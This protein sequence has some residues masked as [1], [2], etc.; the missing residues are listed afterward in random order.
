[1]ILCRESKRL[2]NV[3][4][5]YACLEDKLQGIS[6]C[7]LVQQDEALIPFRLYVAKVNVNNVSLLVDPAHQAELA[8]QFKGV[9]LIDTDSIYP[10]KFESIGVILAIPAERAMQC[11]RYGEDFSVQSTCLSNFGGPQ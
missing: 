9:P 6:E 4:L 11:G 8:I 3:F 5:C 1:M 7:Q 10:Y 2:E